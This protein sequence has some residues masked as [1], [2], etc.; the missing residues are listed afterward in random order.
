MKKKIALVYGGNSSEWQISVLSGKNVASVLDPAKYEIYEILLRG[1]DWNCDGA[2][3]DK[4]DFSLTKDGV[5]IK[6]D[7]AMIMIHGTPGENGLL[8]GYFE[9]I[10]MP[11]TTSS[12]Y[13]SALTFDKYACKTYMRDINIPLAKDVYLRRGDSFDPKTIAGYLGL[14]LF[15]KP[16]DGGSS[17]GVTKVKCQEDIP[18]AVEA[19]FSEGETVLL[20]SFIGGRE[21]TQGVFMDGDDIVTLPITE[22]VSH[23]EFFDYDA[24]YNG[25]SDE[26]CPASISQETVDMI[27]RQTRR[28][29]HHFGC[30]GMIRCDYILTPE[31]KAYFL[32]MNTV[33]GM[34]KMS[35][36][37]VQ[38]AKAGL[39]LGEVFDK[40][41]SSL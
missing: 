3:I 27:S 10:G 23:N 18:A 28:I 21:L 35:L 6:F 31:G 14:P 17:F 39:D 13:V 30:R 15:V 11:F 40:I 36:V 4:T 29:Y 22:I 34:T 7:L 8:Q 2:Q 32:E 19:A 25:K 26:I 16:T 9:M 41:I 37:P 33:P 38:V 20:E 5:K 24:K 1:S 12:A